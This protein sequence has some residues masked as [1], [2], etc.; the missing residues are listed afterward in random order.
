MS[1]VVI[2]MTQLASRPPLEG[3]VAPRHFHDLGKLLLAFVMVWAYFSFSQYLLIWSANIP[4][5]TRWYLHRTRGGW[6]VVAIIVILFHFA[7]PFFL[8]LSRDLKRNARKLALIALLVM[9]MRLVD[10]F[11]Y[12]VPEFRRGS[13]GMSYMDVLLPLGIGGIW[14]AVF[15]WQLRQS[16]LLPVND[17][18]LES[19]I[20][21]GHGGH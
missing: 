21:P 20:A 12:V 16:P 3:V 9:A 4:E 18:Y 19:A 5:E 7:F 1:F 10:L 11:W 8:L 6:G 13:F 15:A 14:L 2:V 17:P